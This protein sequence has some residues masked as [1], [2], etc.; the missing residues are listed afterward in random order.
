M[1][2]RG[3]L[4]CITVWLAVGVNLPAQ[5]PGW[6]SAPDLVPPSVTNLDIAPEEPPD[7]AFEEELQ[8][9]LFAIQDPE[10]FHEQLLQEFPG[11]AVIELEEKFAITQPAAY[12]RAHPPTPTERAAEAI[13]AHA[14]LNPHFPI[15]K[16]GPLN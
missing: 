3:I 6:S 16:V 11:R 9:A 10:A 15:S 13:A 5:P 8:T 4:V 12:L 2:S 1:T 14:I 7:P